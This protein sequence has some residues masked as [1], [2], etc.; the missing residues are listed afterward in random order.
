MILLVGNPAG[1]RMKLDSNSRMWHQYAAGINAQVTCLDISAKGRITLIAPPDRA[2]SNDLAGGIIADCLERWL[3]QNS[4]FP[5]ATGSRATRK[6]PP[7]WHSNFRV[8]GQ[9]ERGTLWSPLR[10]GAVKSCRGRGTIRKV[11]GS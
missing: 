8:A 9:P 3:G 1:A 5:I 4:E 6:L 11:S 10:I 7:T 2:V